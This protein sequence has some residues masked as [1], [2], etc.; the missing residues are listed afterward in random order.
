MVK[1]VFRSVFI[2]HTGTIGGWGGGKVIEITVSGNYCLSDSIPQ[3]SLTVDYKD[4][5][6]LGFLGIQ[7][8]QGTFQGRRPYTSDY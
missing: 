3:R 6:E 8:T 5:S 1:Q 2:S 4:T 7:A